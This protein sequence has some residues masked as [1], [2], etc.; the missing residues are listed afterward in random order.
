MY[1]N[2]ARLPKFG[3]K[4]L[5]KNSTVISTKSTMFDEKT[6]AYTEFKEECTN[7]GITQE[8]ID[9]LFM[10]NMILLSLP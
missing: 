2:I 1:V 7:S 3:F 10:N 9:K 8:Q 6:V 4:K 5:P